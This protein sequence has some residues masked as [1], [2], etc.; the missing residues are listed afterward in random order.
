[1][2]NEPTRANVSLCLNESTGEKKRGE[3]LRRLPFG[4]ESPFVDLA[5]IDQTGNL[6]NIWI[7]M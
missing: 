7:C 4:V 1:M 5:A 3:I 2:M 6:E